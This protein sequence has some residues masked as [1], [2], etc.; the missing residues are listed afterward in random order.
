MAVVWKALARGAAGFARPVAIKEIKAEYRTVKKYVQMF[1]EEARIGTELAHPNIIQVVDFFAEDSTYYLVLEWVDGLDLQ[2]F[3][4]A[5]SYMQQPM[6]WPL[7]LAIGVASLQGLAAAHERLGVDGKANPVIHRDVSP[8]NI[9]LGT[10]GTVKLSDF[11]L[12]RARDRLF[13][14]T[15]PGMVKGKLGYFAPEVAD[16]HSHDVLSDQFAMGVVLWEALVGRRLFSGATDLEVFEA[17]RRGGVPRVDQERSDLPNR[18]AEAVARALSYDRSR[19]FG[20]AREL[21][22]ELSACL[23]S[24]GNGLFEAQERLGKA[25]VHAREILSREEGS[26]NLAADQS[27]QVT[28]SIQLDIDTASFD[29]GT[30]PGGSGA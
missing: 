17:I 9:L 13:S 5:F 7:A 3:I 28:W 24:L 2:S 12:A 16:G 14:L 26:R 22:A 25:V 18:V 10:S 4:R 21:A 8:H 15:A 20:G 1:I 19:R 23:H 11:G 29:G 6:P 30:K 27:D